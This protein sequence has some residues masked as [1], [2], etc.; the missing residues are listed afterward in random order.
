MFHGKSKKVIILKDIHSNLFEEAILVLKED[1]EPEGK[2][3][4]GGEGK[5]KSD[6]I[7]REAETVINNYIKE[8]KVKFRPQKKKRLFKKDSGLMKRFLINSAVLGSIAAAIYL[9]VKLFL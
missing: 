8:N 3:K 9:L 4:S 2:I 6:F 5:I 1:K 7:L